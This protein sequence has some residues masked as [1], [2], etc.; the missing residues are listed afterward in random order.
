MSYIIK[1]L[2]L[3]IALT[4]RVGAERPDCQF[5]EESSSF[6]INYLVGALELVLVA[7]GAEEARYL[8]RVWWEV[9]GEGAVLPKVASTEVTADTEREHSG[10]KYRNTHTPWG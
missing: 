1:D 5:G 7:L 4:L 6:H 2:N 3:Y 8:A 9:V 10:G